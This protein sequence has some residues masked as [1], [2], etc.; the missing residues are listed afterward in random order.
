MEENLVL[1]MEQRLNIVSCKIVKL[2]VNG[3]NGNM[4][5]ALSHVEVANK[6]LY[7]QK[8]LKLKME[9]EI[10]LLNSAMFETPCFAP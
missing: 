8:K 1:E 4:V 2:I 10:A 9:E 6:S 3:Q 7:E 5:H